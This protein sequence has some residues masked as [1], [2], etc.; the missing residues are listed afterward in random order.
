[1]S[2]STVISTNFFSDS[3][4]TP[5]GSVSEYVDKFTELID[6]LKSYNPNPDLLAYTTRFIDGLCDESMTYA[7]LFWLLILLRWILRT[8]LPCCRRKL[9]THLDAK[10][11][12][13]RITPSP[14]FRA[15]VG[16]LPF[17]LRSP[18]L[19][20]TRMRERTRRYHSSHIPWKTS[21]RLSSP[22]VAL[23]VYVSA[24]AISGLPAIGA[25]LSPNCT[26]CK[27]FG[28]FFRIPLGSSQRT[29]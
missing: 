15:G 1:M 22:F 5:H 12:A 27:K 14:S 13:R 3:S 7:L 8:L 11:T 21:S 25:L 4:L 23:M 9:G 29:S 28:S 2:V 26:H 16:Q 19:A 17:P 10:N 18:M 6:Q 20:A 24:A